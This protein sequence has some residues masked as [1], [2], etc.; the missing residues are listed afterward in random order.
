MALTKL[1]R[2][3]I[4]VDFFLEIVSIIRLKIKCIALKVKTIHKT[5][6]SLKI[7]KQERSLA[8][9]FKIM[10]RFRNRARED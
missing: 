7:S 1:L 2:T 8:K 3:T 5:R 4:T 10:R 6:T 9:E